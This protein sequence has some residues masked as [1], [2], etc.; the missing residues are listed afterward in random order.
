M[1]PK[2]PKISADSILEALSAARAPLTP[3]DLAERERAIY[4][5][6]APKD[7]PAPKP[8][9]AEGARCIL[10]PARSAVCVT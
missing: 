3:A 6:Q 2:S 7:K 1:T 10:D 8:P 4:R 5:E 9:A